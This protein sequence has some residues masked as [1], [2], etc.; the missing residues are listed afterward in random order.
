MHFFISKLT[1]LP[2]CLMFFFDKYVEG[3]VGLLMSCRNFDISEISEPHMW[4]ET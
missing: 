3:I 2:P 1:S 4:S